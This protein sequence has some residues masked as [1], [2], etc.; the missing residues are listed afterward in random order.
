MGALRFNFGHVPA[1]VL[2]LKGLAARVKSAVFHRIGQA[3]NSNLGC[4]LTA[5]FE[6]VGRSLGLSLLAWKRSVILCK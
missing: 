6:N 4:L 1:T 5:I 2:L 3:H